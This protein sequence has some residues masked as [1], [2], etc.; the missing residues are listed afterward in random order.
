MLAAGLVVV[1]AIARQMSNSVANAQMAAAV[2]AVLAAPA[3]IHFRPGAIDHHNA[4][5][6]L[7]LVLVLL[8]SQ[9]EQSAVKAGLAGLVASLSLGIG[10]E[11]LPALHAVG[12]S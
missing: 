1:A 8:T 12:L 7:L 4:Q 3:L 10:I 5:I 2:L 9:I 11:M 6:V